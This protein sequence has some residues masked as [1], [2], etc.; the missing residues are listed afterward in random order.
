HPRQPITPVTWH[1]GKQDGRPSRRHA[2]RYRR[3]RRRATAARPERPHFFFSPDR[4]FV[5]IVSSVSSCFN[6]REAPPR[7]QTL[8]ARRTLI[9]DR[10]LPRLPIEAPPNGDERERRRSCRAPPPPEQ[11]G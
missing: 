8:R 9:A 6:A 11:D 4:C 10:W 5:S 1:A 2:S 3:Y 7:T